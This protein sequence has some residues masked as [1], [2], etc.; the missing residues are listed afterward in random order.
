MTKPI[1]PLRLVLSGGGIRGISYIGVFL[2]LE[3]RGFLKNI[4]EILGVSCGALFG[5]AF[6]IGYTPKELYEFAISFDFTLLINVEPDLILEFIETYGVDNKQNI[7]KLL[8]SLLKNKGYSKDITYIEL[9][10]KTKFN[11]R[12]LATNINKCSLQEFSYKKTPTTK[13]TF[14]I[15]SS[16]CIP[17]YFIPCIDGVNTYV[18]GGVMNNYPIDLLSENELNDTLGFTF[19]EDHIVVE[20]IP[21][22]LDFFHQIY[23]C[24]YISKKTKVLSLMKEKTVVIPCG[25]YTMMNFSINKE[26]KEY[27]ISQGRKSLENYFNLYQFSEKPKRRYSVS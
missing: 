22:I 26:E 19:S 15:L 20:T 16:M 24:I 11:I 4:I 7:E 21:N 23:A 1:P 6:S 27:L 14:G 3:K 13:V 2:E 25:H 10:E 9:F 12:F 5:F 18:D 17:G 8:D